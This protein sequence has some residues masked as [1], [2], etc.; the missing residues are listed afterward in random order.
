MAEDQASATVAFGF[1]RAARLVEFE[2]TTIKLAGRAK[3]K[4]DRAKTRRG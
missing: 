3:I 1:V 4:A 2:L